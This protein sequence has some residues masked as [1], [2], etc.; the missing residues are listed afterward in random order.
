LSLHLKAVIFDLDGTL[1]NSVIPFKEMKRMIIKRL[2]AIG[3]THGL[4]NDEMLN[5]DIAQNALQDMQNKG[6]TQQRIQQAFDEVSEIMNDF[7]LKSIGKA[8]LIR[9]VPET[10]K[11]LKTRKIK[12]GVMTRSCREYA[13]KLL[14]KFGLR[15]FFD[16]V[17]ARDDVTNPKPDPEHAFYMLRLLGVSPQEA[18]YVGD[19]WSDAECA[20]RAGLKFV[21][22]GQEK[23]ESVERVRKLG[24]E[25]I[26]E[27]NEIA[28]LLF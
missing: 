6:F 4:L 20:R 1:I 10:L 9:G 27:I 2:E 19:H 15:N 22:V 28:D 11:A 23:K 14:A 17:V 8:T 7:E 24:F 16:A 12:L 13:E 25:V 3:V 5:F 21:L 26:D 18:L